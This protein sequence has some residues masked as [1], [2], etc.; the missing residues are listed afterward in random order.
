MIEAVRL[1]HLL[2]EDEEVR[3][4]GFEVLEGEDDVLCLSSP[5][6]LDPRPNF[7]ARAELVKDMAAFNRANY[8]C[9]KTHC[10]FEMSQRRLSLGRV[11]ALR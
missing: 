8:A 4:D 6:Q 10:F 3:L 11:S 1:H 5:Q 2:D 7:E 9:G